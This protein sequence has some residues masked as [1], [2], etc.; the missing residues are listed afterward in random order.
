MELVFDGRPSDSPLVE[1]IWRTQSEYAGTFISEAETRS[2]IVVTKYQGKTSLTFR[3]PETKATSADYPPEAEFFGIVLKLGTYMP[4]LPPTHLLDRK[5]MTLPEA[6]SQSF[7]LLGMAWQIPTFENSDTFV[8][9]LVRQSLLVREPVV[10]AALQG[11]LKDLSLRSVQRRFLRATGLSHN[12]VYQIERAKR[13]M[14]LLQQ[15]VSIFDTVYEAGYAD[16]PHLTRALKR[17]LGQTPAQV[18]RVNFA[19]SDG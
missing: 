19:G 17:F 13:A 8:D 3:G 10:E 7:W 12:T 2:E 6:T 5:D 15:G 14:A 18:A 16:Q 11:H 9:R 1:M 4:H